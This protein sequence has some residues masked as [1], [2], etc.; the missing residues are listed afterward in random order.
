M[1][2]RVSLEEIQK[3]ILIRF[4]S[5]SFEI[6]KY[7]GLGKPGQ[8]RCLNCN[9]TI[10]IN[11][12]NNF[13]AKNKRYGCKNCH[14]LWRAR[15]EKI[16]KIKEKY[17]ILETQIK[18]THTYYT[19]EC[20][21]CKRIRKTYLSNLMTCLDCGCT[22]KTYRGR[23]NSEF[24]N[25]CNQNY[26][27]ELELIGKYINQTTK[28]LIKHKPCGLIWNVRPSDIISGKSHC[29]KCRTQESLG[30]KKIREYLQS[31]N[32]NFIQEKQLDDSRQR[33]D[34]F[35]PNYN[36]A[37]QYN[38]KQHYYFT[39]FFHKTLKGFQEH[40]KR[41]QKK[42]QYCKRNQI[43]LLE[44]SYLDDKKIKEILNKTLNKFND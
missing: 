38:G 23:T 42:R 15:E 44:I 34:F 8:I 33:F 9:Q 30:V 10:T 36:L 39:P 7:Q 27:N 16:A 18:N 43:Q 19:I 29:P 41:D 11:K 31:E 20:K 40:Q 26:N 1:G 22:T 24:I 17:N 37:I 32:I 14:G 3:R 4:P 6:V 25:E 13:F 5:Q 35:L 28:V 2:K 12:F 21:K